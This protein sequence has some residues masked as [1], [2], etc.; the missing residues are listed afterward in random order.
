MLLTTLKNIAVFTGIIAALFISG[1]ST[2]NGIIKEGPI[3]LQRINSD[4]AQVTNTFLET[5]K[6]TLVLRGEL[7]RRTQQRGAI[8]GHLKVE[9]IDHNGKIIKED[10]INYMR[11]NSKS[12]NAKF[13]YP[14]QHDLSFISTVRITHHDD[15]QL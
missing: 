10:Q 9:L 5:I 12:S 3:N 13:S 7:K 15:H 4:T 11:N 8:P 6:S 1:C 2:D 14:I